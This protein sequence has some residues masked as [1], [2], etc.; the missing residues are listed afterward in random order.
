MDALIPLKKKRRLPFRKRG[1]RP[2]DH[3]ATA[4]FGLPEQK[5]VVVPPR[6]T[7]QLEIPFSENE[8]NIPNWKQW[9]EKQ[10]TGHTARI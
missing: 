7:K 6:P 4:T 8:A 3:V 9:T 5:I 1:E 10:S 2:C